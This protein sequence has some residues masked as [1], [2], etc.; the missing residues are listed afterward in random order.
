MHGGHVSA[1]SEGLGYGCEIV[2]ALP[3]AGPPASVA[4]QAPVVT[5]TSGALVLLIEDNVDAAQSLAEILELSGHRVR[6]AYDGTT[7]IRMAVELKPEVV[8]CD[9]GL[10]DV[11][12]YEVARTLRADQL[13]RSTRLIAVTGYAQYSDK[14]KAAEAG[15]DA[16]LTKPPDLAS[17]RR[18][19]P[20]NGRL[21]PSRQSGPPEAPR[22]SS[23]V[24][25]PTLQSLALVILLT[26]STAPL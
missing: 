12:G 24:C 1:N 19:A 25:H 10:P 17:A 16:H 23:A 15:F 13:L 3:L 26:H 14:Q 11:N 9:I 4:D 5:D 20:H 21:G 18:D 6:L 8:L 2:V 7:G 22:C